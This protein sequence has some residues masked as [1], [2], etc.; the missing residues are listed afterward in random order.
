MCRFSYHSRDH[1]MGDE[2]TKDMKAAPRTKKPGEYD[3][4]LCVVQSDRAPAMRELTRHT[5]KKREKARPTV[6]THHCV[7]LPAWE[8][9][10]LR[11]IVFGD[12]V[13]IPR[14]WAGPVR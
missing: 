13:S 9:S 10:Y 2:G 11:H 5:A 3:D 14:L 1:V 12:T 4:V 6:S 8:Q 7:T